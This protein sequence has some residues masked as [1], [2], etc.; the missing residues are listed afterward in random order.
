MRQLRDRKRI[1]Y[2]ASD[3]EDMSVTQNASKRFRG[4]QD[5]DYYC[6]TL[7]S[8]INEEETAPLTQIYGKTSQN[9]LESSTT[10]K[11]ISLTYNTIDTTLD[12]AEQSNKEHKIYFTNHSWKHYNIQYNS[13]SHNTNNTLDAAKY[14]E[15]PNV[16]QKLHQSQLVLQSRKRI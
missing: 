2:Y 12:A 1:K 7:E 10:A 13:L 9:T 14:N 8:N 3:D 4:E 5:D 15:L 11:I 6:E 16:E